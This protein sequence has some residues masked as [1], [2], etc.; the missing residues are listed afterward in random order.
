MSVAAN[1]YAKALIDVLYPDNAQS[2]FEQLNAL[3]ALLREQPDGIKVLANPTISV[4]RRKALLKEIG[5]ALGFN[6]SIR[7][8]VDLLVERNR[9]NLFEEIIPAYQKMMDEHLGIVHAHGT[10]ARPLDS[11]EQPEL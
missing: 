3:A 10:A 11:G 2:G 9:F 8:F 7:N 4:E 5:D 6:K 1:R